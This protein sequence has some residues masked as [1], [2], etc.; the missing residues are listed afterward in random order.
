[1][2]VIRGW[3]YD[4]ARS[5]F[6]ILSGEMKSVLCELCL[7]SLRTCVVLLL[8]LNVIL[9][10]NLETRLPIVKYGRNGSYF[11]Y[12]VAAH[13]SVEEVKLVKNSW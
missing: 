11:G 9:C 13:Q 2:F 6:E 4:R 1:M 3:R 7:Q 5:A 8:T 10:F 12:S